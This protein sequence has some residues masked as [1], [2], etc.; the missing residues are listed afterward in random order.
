MTSTNRRLANPNTACAS[1]NMTP[2][3]K[4]SEFVGDY[5]LLVVAVLLIGIGLGVAYGAG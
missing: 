3:E 2:L 5:T 4:L 1:D